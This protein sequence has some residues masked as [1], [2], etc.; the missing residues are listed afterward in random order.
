MR[1]HSMPES[2]V[3]GGRNSLLGGLILVALIAL[4][5]VY[6]YAL[7]LVVDLAVSAAL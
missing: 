2:T 1:E 5:V 7:Y 3:G 6:G 4:Y